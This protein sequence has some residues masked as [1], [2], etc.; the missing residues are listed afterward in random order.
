MPTKT[1]LPDIVLFCRKTIT[2]LILCTMSYVDRLHMIL[3]DTE[4]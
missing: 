2:Y 1:T 4:H 3:T